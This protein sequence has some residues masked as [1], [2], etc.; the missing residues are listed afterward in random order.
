MKK[1]R[2]VFTTVE[3]EKKALKK[4]NVDLSEALEK[5]QQGYS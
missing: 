3:S 1:M 4:K 5:S 2:N